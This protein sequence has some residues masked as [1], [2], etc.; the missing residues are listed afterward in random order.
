MISVWRI[1][2]DLNSVLGS[3]PTWFRVGVENDLV[4]GLDIVD[5]VFVG[6]CKIDL[7]L[8]CG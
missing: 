8:E 3:K 4:S 2:V 5:L 6:A 1:G 7:L